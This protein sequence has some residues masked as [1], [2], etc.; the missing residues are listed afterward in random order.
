MS[1]EERRSKQDVTQSDQEPPSRPAAKHR[2]TPAFWIAL[3]LL[4]LA[5]YM[6]ERLFVGGTLVIMVGPIV[7]ALLAWPI[8]AR[9]FP[10]AKN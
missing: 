7:A 8:A 5:I 2:Y 1:D 10:P 3:I 6:V 4:M 9:L